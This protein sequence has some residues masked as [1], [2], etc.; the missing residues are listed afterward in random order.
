MDQQK[1]KPSQLETWGAVL[2]LNS[3]LIF[4]R[5]WI[6]TLGKS[7]SDGTLWICASLLLVGFSLLIADT[8]NKP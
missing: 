6:L 1:I 2:V 5:S 7:L 4:V 3:A 8:P